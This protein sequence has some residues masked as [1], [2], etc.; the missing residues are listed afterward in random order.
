MAEFEQF[1]GKRT[2][3]KEEID[4]NA[5]L[6]ELLTTGLIKATELMEGWTTNQL[7]G[8][9]E[10]FNGL[11]HVIKACLPAEAGLT[12]VK[13]LRIFCENGAIEYKVEQPEDM[14]FAVSEILSGSTATLCQNCEKQLATLWCVA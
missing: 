3:V 6:L 9:S 1:T 5:E 7:I 4:A 10:S 8:S 13:T 14:I 2:K 12:L 11:V